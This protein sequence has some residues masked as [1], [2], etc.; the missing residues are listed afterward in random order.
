MAS[1]TANN[2]QARN[3][4]VLGIV[5]I[6]EKALYHVFSYR[7][8]GVCVIDC[9]D[10]RVRITRQ[11]VCVGKTVHEGTFEGAYCIYDGDVVHVHVVGAFGQGI[12]LEIKLCEIENIGA[13]KGDA[14]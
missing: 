12:I 2:G 5:K 7:D 10:M 13:V 8:A 4:N 11:K 1:V 6:I 3:G 14:E 9:T